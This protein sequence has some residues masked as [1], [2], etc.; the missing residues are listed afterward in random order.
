MG[1]WGYKLFQSDHAYD[2]IEA[3]E[4]DA[5]LPIHFTRNDAEKTTAQRTL[6][7]GLL[8]RLSAKYEAEVATH[9]LILLVALA[10][11]VG[12]TISTELLQKTKTKNANLGIPDQAREQMKDG[13]GGQP[14]NGSNYVMINMYPRVSCCADEFVL[15]PSVVINAMRARQQQEAA[16]RQQ[17]Q[18][19]QQ[20]AGVGPFCHTCRKTQAQ[21]QN[22]RILR[23]CARCLT[24][25][26]VYCSRECQR[27]DWKRHKKVCKAAK[28]GEGAE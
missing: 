25:G 16:Q 2:L 23:R 13:A 1:Y 26:L 14:A 17:Q 22:N 24:D 28:G 10:M 6:N 20:Q 12:A 15:D 4:D 18:Q 19:T 8:A 3:I 27:K 7:S 9:K 11:E 5:N 21:L